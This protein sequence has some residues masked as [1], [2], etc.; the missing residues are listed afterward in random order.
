MLPA[1]FL[2]LLAGDS[3]GKA[4]KLL[5]ALCPG[6]RWSPELRRPFPASGSAPPGRETTVLLNRLQSS[7]VLVGNASVSFSRSSFQRVLILSKVSVQRD[8]WQLI[9]DPN[10]V[11]PYPNRPGT[12][13]AGTGG[14]GINICSHPDL[15]F[16]SSAS[17]PRPAAAPGVEQCP[18]SSFPRA[19]GYLGCLSAK[20]LIATTRS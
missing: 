15:D 1:G 9:P 14:A 12:S 6:P 8:T 20:F 11:S 19:R 17:L 18:S 10:K 16:P 7:L 4:E 3:L 2:A 5:L 13:P